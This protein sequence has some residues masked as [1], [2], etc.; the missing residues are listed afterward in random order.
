MAVSIP[1]RLCPPLQDFWTEQIVF[2]GHGS[3]TS[4]GDP[5]P[6]HPESECPRHGN[7][8]AAYDYFSPG[9]EGLIQSNLL[10]LHICVYNLGMLMSKLQLMLL[11]FSSYRQRVLC[12]NP[13]LSVCSRCHVFLSDSCARFS[14][15]VNITMTSM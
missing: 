14:Q 10:P 4:Y 11:F 3:S 1:R 2:S 13:H 7:D 15:W 9:K 12:Q 8:M 5:P 6:S